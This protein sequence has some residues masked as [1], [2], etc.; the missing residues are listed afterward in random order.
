MTVLM[1]QAL[2]TIT[3]EEG[4]IDNK[5]IIYWDLLILFIVMM[6]S[7]N[8][9]LVQRLK[10][11]SDDWCV[12]LIIFAVSAI[13]FYIAQ[14]K[15]AK[16]GNHF[17]L[18]QTWIIQISHTTRIITAILGTILL[19]LGIAELIW[20]FIPYSQHAGLYLFSILM[21]YSCGI[22][23]CYQAL[24]DPVQEKVDWRVLLKKRNDTEENS[25][26]AL[27]EESVVATKKRLKVVYIVLS[28]L[29]LTTFISALILQYPT[30]SKQKL[31]VE[32]IKAIIITVTALFFIKFMRKQRKDT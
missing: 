4:K 31:V 14:K 3:S 22:G 7:G 8:G 26:S 15:R 32:I 29:M 5:N 21:F 2:K 25:V 17:G 9:S 28:I 10:S 1:K 13:M 19:L 23:A 6:L 24:Y 11:H 16:K 12:W 27:D 18:E 20:N 30:D